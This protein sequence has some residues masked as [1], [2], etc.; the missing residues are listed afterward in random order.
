MNDWASYAALFTAALLAATILPAQSEAV[1]VG[2]MLTGE[3]PVWILLVVAS[4]GNTAGSCMTWA[5]GRYIVR[6]Q[7]HKWFPVKPEALR[8]A[9]HFYQRYGK[10]SLL[11]SWV[12]VIGDPLTMV[13]GLLREPFSVFLVLVAL[14]KTTRYIALAAITTSAF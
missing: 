3:Q 10:W 6:F 11:L 7:N 4:I 14:V 12:P 13:A 1:L 5:L 8:K 2:L 9:Q